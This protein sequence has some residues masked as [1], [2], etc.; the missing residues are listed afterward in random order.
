[1]VAQVIHIQRHTTNDIYSLAD[2]TGMLDA[3][4]WH[5]PLST[6]THVNEDDALFRCELIDDFAELQVTFV[7]V[8]PRS[9][10]L[11]TSVLHR[12]NCYA[13]VTGTIDNFGSAKHI[14]TF[15][16]KYIER[17]QDFFFHQCTVIAQDISIHGPLV[18]NFTYF[19]PLL[20]NNITSPSTLRIHLFDTFLQ[21]LTHGMTRMASLRI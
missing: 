4:Y 5:S 2:G 7:V 19:Q 12:S 13:H 8:Q 18:S 15:N 21:H 10:L 9:E 20:T 16:M 3:R 1:L 6:G 17:S 11:L 14:N